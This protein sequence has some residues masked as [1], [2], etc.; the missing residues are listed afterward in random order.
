MRALNRQHRQE[1]GGRRKEGGKQAKGRGGVGGEGEERK[2]RK[3]K[4]RG[5]TDAGGQIPCRLT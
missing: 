4:G 5:G 1:E 2:M 3:C